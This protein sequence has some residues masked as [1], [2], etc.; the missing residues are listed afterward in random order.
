MSDAANVGTATIVI[1]DIDSIDHAKRDIFIIERSGCL[2]LRMVTI[3]LIDPKIDE[4]PKIFRPK[5]HISAAGPGALNIGMVDTQSAVSENPRQTKAA[6]GVIRIQQH[7][8]LAI[9][10]PYLTIMG[11]WFP[12]QKQGIAHK[13]NFA[14]HELENLLKS[15]GH[16]IYRLGR[17]KVLSHGKSRPPPT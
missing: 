4:M 8:S 9:P 10:Y 7:S 14:V 6:E 15:K 17:K 16:D 12:P 5:I 3:K 13:N 1:N 2:H 11:E